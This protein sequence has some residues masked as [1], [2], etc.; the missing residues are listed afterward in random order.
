MITVLPLTLEGELVQLEPLDIGH[1]QGLFEATKSSEELWRHMSIFP[2][3]SIS[4]IDLFIE[5]AL[6]DQATGTTV[7]FAIIDRSTNDVVGST[8]YL[9]IRSIHSGLEIGWTFLATRLW[10]TGI[11]TECKY[12]LLR[13]AFEDVG[14]A[15]VQL[16]T[17]ARNERSRNA[18]LRVGAQFEGILRTHQLRRDGTL[19]DTAMYSIID[20]E[21]PA[22]EERL[23]AHMQ[24]RPTVSPSS[25]PGRCHGTHA[26]SSPKT[27]RVTARRSARRQSRSPHPRARD[28]HDDAG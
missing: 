24:S 5:C 3:E 26:M 20:Q 13:H 12:L 11:N 28:R 1:A 23:E 10:R 4:D 19:R 27:V 22:V 9:D 7:P 2:P 18:I 14:C 16:K 25:N 6:R 21:W 8:R 15:R 17:D